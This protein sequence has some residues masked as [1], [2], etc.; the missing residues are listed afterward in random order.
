M[1]TL[2]Y[3]F[4]TNICYTKKPKHGK[5]KVKAYT[6]THIKLNIKFIKAWPEEG[7]GE[8]KHWKTC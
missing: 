6:L 5:S 1:E 4:H 8:R 7:A 3:L 2:E